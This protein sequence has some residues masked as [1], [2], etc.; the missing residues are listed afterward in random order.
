MQCPN[1]KNLQDRVL[2]SRNNTENTSIRRRRQC[3]KCGHRFT[4]HENIEDEPLNII[5]KNNS[6]ERYNKKKISKGVEQ[7]L[8]KRPFK[9][10]K[11][12]KLIDNIEKDIFELGK[13]SK[14]VSSHDIGEIILKRLAKA[15]SVAYIRFASVYLEFKSVEEF[16][17]SISKITK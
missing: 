12:E 10:A 9:Q 2:E 3:L 17:D 16:G 15:D 1:C 14:E 7:A 6:K 5:K 13:D 8:K 11:I 4:S